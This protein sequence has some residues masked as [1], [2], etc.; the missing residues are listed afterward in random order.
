VFLADGRIVDELRK[1]TSD[2][3]LERMKLLDCRIVEQGS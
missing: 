1:P 3:V 2:L